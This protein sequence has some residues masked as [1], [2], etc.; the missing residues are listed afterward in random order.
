MNNN[1]IIDNKNQLSNINYEVILEN[2]E[3]EI[4]SIN[5]IN[6]GGS[7][8]LN[9]LHSISNEI[10]NRIMNSN[11][12][13]S[14]ILELDSSKNISTISINHKDEINFRKK[15]KI[16]DKNINKKLKSELFI[17]SSESFQNLETYKSNILN[18]HN[19]FGL[20]YNFQNLKLIRGKISTTSDKNNKSNKANERLRVD[21]A[22]IDIN[23]L[24]IESDLKEN[25]KK[26]INK[27]EENKQIDEDLKEH[28]FEELDKGNLKVNNIIKVI[29]SEALGRI[30]RSVSYMYLQY[31]CE[32][33]NNVYLKDY[34]RR[35][36][37]LDKFL[38]DL[39][40]QAENNSIILDYDI[41][42]IL[43]RGNAFDELPI[44]GIVEGNIFEDK[45]QEHKLSK[46]ALKLKLNGNVNKDGNN[47]NYNSKNSKSCYRYYT[48]ILLDSKSKLSKRIKIF[49]IYMFML[50]D[51][52]DLYY[53]PIKDFKNTKS[54]IE[55]INNGYET[56]KEKF[57]NICKRLVNVLDDKTN[58]DT[59]TKLNK[60]VSE[61]DKIIR[62]KVGDIDKK[63]EKYSLNLVLH[64]NI[65]DI[66]KLD[67]MELFKS[68]EYDI[69]YL[70]YVSISEKNCE[71][72][73]ENIFKNDNSL[74]DK[75]MSTTDSND[76]LLNY[77]I[78]TSVNINIKSYNLYE[79]DEYKETKSLYKIDNLKSVPIVMY[80]A[81]LKE[82]NK[83]YKV[84]FNELV[85][86][87]IYNKKCIYLATLQ[88]EDILEKEAN[89]YLYRLV[90]QTLSY[91]IIE[92]IL[93]L[94][95]VKDKKEIF[96]PII[97]YH[98]KGEKKKVSKCDKFIREYSKLLSH[99]F[100][101]EYR[102]SSQGFDVSKD[103]SR[104][105]NFIYKNAMASL[106]SKV[107]KYF[108]E[109]DMGDLNKMAMIVVTSK[110]CDNSYEDSE[111]ITTLFGDVILFDKKDNKVLCDIHSSFS[112][113]YRDYD[114]YTNP[115]ILRSKVSSLYEKGYK[116][117][118]YI[119]KAPYTSTLNITKKEDLFFMDEKIINFISKGKNDLVIYPLYYDNFYA[120]DYKQNDS[121]EALYIEDTEEL[122]SIIKLKS[123]SSVS[124][125]NLYSGKCVGNN[126]NEKRY[127]SVI[128][129]Q[130]LCNL[131]ENKVLNNNINEALI[132]NSKTKRSIMNFI[133]MYHY[134][135]YEG[136][137]KVSIKMNPYSNLMGDDGIF[138][139]STKEF[140]LGK[141]TK[142]KSNMLAY[143]TEVKKSMEGDL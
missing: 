143:L 21:E 57:E 60:M 139:L 44:N 135:R 5:V 64:T 102:C 11:K 93:K 83:K 54:Y 62:Y 73:D 86:K 75:V 84:V 63:G 106:Y 116:N 114:L 112:D 38:I 71:L 69:Q 118:L 104:K 111:N 94:I 7:I 126:S 80:P 13:I 90:Y 24:K 3:K 124:V 41:T 88:D 30:K 2:I 100:S 55:N 85:K 40:N 127:T 26:Y 33:T 95:K 113:N 138:G 101:N 97:R 65:I 89:H 137:S 132:K 103:V 107:P 108:E 39:S 110:K 16:I 4:N 56:Q 49:C 66:S 36:K 98:D 47:I 19:N 45:S 37:L 128:L 120:I 51:L 125:F 22:T 43:S 31:L 109:V 52:G 29:D 50:K 96:I 70:K 82:N 121:T 17:N 105:G 129:Y 35:F 32:K 131:Y 61:L 119:A 58:I 122:K 67:H 34:T 123:K 48:D 134:A 9:N 1:R 68:Q 8:Y 133:T 12:K 27:I 23:T 53:D 115:M 91:M 15:I 79:T 10:T 77:L 46:F 76:N 81:S 42:N 99:I 20:D 78:S 130:T 136:S 28:L 142:I 18:N 140:E 25:L 141:F 6:K 74:S 72:L 14:D 87:T 117:I 92:N 59:T